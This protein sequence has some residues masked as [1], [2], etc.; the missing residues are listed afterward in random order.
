VAEQDF[1]N[2]Y[3]GVVYPAPRR[4]RRGR[5]RPPG[6]VLDRRA[7]VST[8]NRALLRHEPGPI[9]HWWVAR[10]LSISEPTLRVYLREYELPW[11]PPWPIA[12]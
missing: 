2:V 8:V 9:Y 7:V 5:G 1:F 3:E 10:A 12:V 6:R 11:P 4:V